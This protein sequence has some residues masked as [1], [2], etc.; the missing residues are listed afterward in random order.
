MDIDAYTKIEYKSEILER[1]LSLRTENM[2][3]LE[4]YTDKYEIVEEQPF[5]DDVALHSNT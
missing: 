2:L 1:Q 3:V 4:K 5:Y